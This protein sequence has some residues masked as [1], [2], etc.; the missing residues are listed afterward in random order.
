VILLLLGIFLILNT[1]TLSSY[2]V[3]D[4][5]FPAYNYLSIKLFS[6]SRSL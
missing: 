5:Y 1:L 3:P 4:G 6:V 2:N